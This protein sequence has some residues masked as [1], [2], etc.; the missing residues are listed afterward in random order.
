M[1]KSAAMCAGL[2]RYWCEIKDARDA[3]RT[4]LLPSN[5]P[6]LDGEFFVIQ[7]FSEWPRL[8]ARAAFDKAWC[9]QISQPRAARGVTG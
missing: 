2:W 8:K 7:E 3:I 5:L 9:E 4:G 6:E 1:N